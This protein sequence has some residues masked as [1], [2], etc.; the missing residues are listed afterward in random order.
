MIAPLLFAAIGIGIIALSKTDQPKAK[1]YN[2]PPPAL[3]PP[4]TNAP[5]GVT[6]AMLSCD[7][8]AQGLPEPLRSAVV[9]AVV[10]GTPAQLR[11]LAGT[12]DG[13]AK[14][15]APPIGP[16]AAQ[17][18]VCL[19]ARATE[20]EGGGSPIFTSYDPTNGLPAGTLPNPGYGG[21][22]PPPIDL[23]SLPGTVNPLGAGALGGP[24]SG[25]SSSGE[26]GGGFGS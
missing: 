15:Y 1:G 25:G 7:A 12:L 13:V 18:A 24:S 26:G 21:F 2:P 16:A 3:P 9:N 6:P 22:T 4:V 5:G 23:N 14:M 11:E 10:K 20:I 17:T 8:S 19:R